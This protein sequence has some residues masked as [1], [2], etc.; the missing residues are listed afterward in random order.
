MEGWTFAALA[1]GVVLSFEFVLFR[2]F[3][4]ERSTAAGV[5]GASDPPDAETESGAADQA[6]GLGA[7]A[8]RDSEADRAGSE[9]TVACEHCGAAN[10][11]EPAVVFCRSCLGRLR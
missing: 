3:T 8:G 7:R 1:L 9:R 2:Y 4:P 10:A 5:D 6:G 11:D